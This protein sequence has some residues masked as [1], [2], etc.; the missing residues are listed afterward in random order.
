VVISVRVLRVPHPVSAQTI[1][2]RV[3]DL[4]A[5][6]RAWPRP[7]GAAEAA[8]VTVLEGLHLSEASWQVVVLNLQQLTQQHSDTVTQQHS[9]TVTR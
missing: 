1:R 8:D 9:D 5:L 7:A 6:M 2:F 4:S 3:L